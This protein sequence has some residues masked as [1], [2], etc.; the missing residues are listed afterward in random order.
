MKQYVEIRWVVSIDFVVTRKYK[1]QNLHHN[2]SQ[3]IWIYHQ[4]LPPPPLDQPFDFQ[5]ELAV[6]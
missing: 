4:P 6:D 3:N 2:L 1:Q 5:P